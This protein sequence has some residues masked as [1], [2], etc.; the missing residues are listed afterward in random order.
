MTSIFLYYLSQFYPLAIGIALFLGLKSLNLF[1]HKTRFSLESSD[2]RSSS[3]DENTFPSTG[4]YCLSDVSEG[5]KMKNAEFLYP[6]PD[7]GLTFFRGHVTS[8]ENPREAVFSQLINDT[9]IIN[10]SRKRHPGNKTFAD[11]GF[12]KFGI[13]DLNHI[14]KETSLPDPKTSL[15]L[16]SPDKEKFLSS[17]LK[18][19][20]YSELL[21]NSA[22]NYGLEIV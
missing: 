14:N 10:G 16:F 7:K 20:M 8:S 21:L 6:L 17:L 4:T 18:P 2:A 9:L 11:V 13:I 1:K 19:G 3:I 22:L 12:R 15:K 5:I